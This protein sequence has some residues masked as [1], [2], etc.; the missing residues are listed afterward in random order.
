MD[1]AMLFR[2]RICQEPSTKNAMREQP[3]E[4]RV[5]IASKGTVERSQVNRAIEFS[6]SVL[7]SGGAIQYS[8]VSHE[9]SSFVASMVVDTFG[10]DDTISVSNAG[11]MKHTIGD[12]SVEVYR[13]S[14]ASLL[15]VAI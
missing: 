6:T 7:L 2:L 11:A 12:V 13:S 3:K 9:G 1:P 14:A 8:T 15:S 4:R 5:P 10:R